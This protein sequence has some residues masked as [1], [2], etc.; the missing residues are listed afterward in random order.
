MSDV[1]RRVVYDCNVFVQALINTNGPS[2][3]C[4]RHA[5]E[6]N[7][8]LFVSEPV[9]GE[10]REAPLKPTPARL[11]VTAERAETLIENL[12]KV[13]VVVRFIPERFTYSRDPD[14]A[15]YV[16]LALASDS[17]L[18]VSRDKDLLCL[19]DGARVEGA[20]FQARFPGLRILDPVE[21]LRELDRSQDQNSEC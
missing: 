16:N 10:I 11:G 15:H 20:D 7:V 1:A 8:S 12:L 21:F 13:A 9:L 17:K 3:A 14:D 5:L 4:V 19:M 18:V 6:K 2:G